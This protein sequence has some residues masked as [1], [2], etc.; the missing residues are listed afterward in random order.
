MSTFKITEEEKW[1][2]GP[3]WVSPAEKEWGGWFNAVF[4]PEGSIKTL[5][6]LTAEQLIQHGY[7]EKTFKQ[8]LD[9]IKKEPE[10]EI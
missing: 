9:L 6:E 1:N 5:A 2:K 3:L 8:A 4:I 10:P 7:R